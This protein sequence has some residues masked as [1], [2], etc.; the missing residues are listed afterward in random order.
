MSRCLRT[1]RR[2]TSSTS[3][4]PAPIPRP[5]RASSTASRCPRCASSSLSG[6]LVQDEV[7]LRPIG[8]GVCLALGL[9]PARAVVRRKPGVA[10]VIPVDLGQYKTRRERQGFG[11]ELLTADNESDQFPAGQRERGFE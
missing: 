10:V 3:A 8:G 1:S 9:P 11:K 4:T 2:A 5:M 7:E 6:R